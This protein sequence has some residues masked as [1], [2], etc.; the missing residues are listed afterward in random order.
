MQYLQAIAMIS[1]AL[2]LCD[3]GGKGSDKVLK[4]LCASLRAQGASLFVK[5]YSGEGQ[6]FTLQTLGRWRSSNHKHPRD[7]DLKAALTKNEALPDGWFERLNAREP[8][9]SAGGLILSRLRVP[10]ILVIP[11]FLKGALS[12]FLVA[13]ELKREVD[14]P[15]ED[16]F[17]SAV[18]SLLELWLTKV[19]LDHRLTCV[20][21]FL[22]YPTLVMDLN[23]VIRAWNKSMVEIS[24]LNKKDVTGKGDYCHAVPFYGK[25]IPTVP[26]LI[27][28][29]DPQGEARYL[30]FRRQGRDAYV[31]SFCPALPGGGAYITCK[32]SLVFD[33]NNR[34]WGAIQTLQDVTRERRMEKT[35][36]QSENMY[37]LIAD[38]AGIGIMLFRKDEILYYNERLSKFTGMAKEFTFNG[39]VEWVFHED[40]TKVLQTLEALL[41]R[42][43]EEASFEFRAGPPKNLSHYRCNTHVVEYEDQPTVHLILDDITKQKE[44][45]EKARLNELRMYH[46]DRLIALGTMAAGIAH[47]LNQPLNTIQVVAEGLLFGKENA[48]PLNTDALYEKLEMVSRQVSRMAGVIQN[49]RNFAREDREQRLEEVDVSR[50]VENVFSMIGR[51]LEIHSVEVKKELIHDLPRISADLN[52]LEQVIMNL[53]VNAR[54]ALDTHHT[55]PKK[56][57]VRTYENQGSVSIEVGDNA[58]GIPENLLVKI[59]DPFFTTKAVG[60]G[61]GLGLTISKSIIA[62]IGG[63]IEVFNNEMGGA[64]FIVSVPGARSIR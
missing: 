53:V 1:S 5:H 6:A 3:G 36:H 41:S 33:V 20:L 45:D 19:S 43:Q 38:F 13:W 14:A 18:Q 56:L 8:L 48:W 37:R 29:P 39:F 57:W 10:N 34:L 7:N 49:I 22:P 15:R 24:G 28:N 62:E 46:E 21:D 23:G 40:R 12:A 25:Q 16:Y 27:L 9:F 4:E 63:C 52:R 47:E 58:N 51:Q 17:F 61:T 35:L 11:L 2:V 26:N 59:F 54:Q 30:E 44:L 31:L 64:T 50:A 32:A 60:K 55:G 42:R